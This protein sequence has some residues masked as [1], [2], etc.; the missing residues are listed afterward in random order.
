MS[1]SHRHPSTTIARTNTPP[2][3]LRVPAAPASFKRTIDLPPEPDDYD[4]NGPYPAG[5]FDADDEDIEMQRYL[6]QMYMS[7][8]KA[9]SFTPKRSS[10]KNETAEDFGFS[11]LGLIDTRPNDH[12]THN[13]KHKLKDDEARR[14][15]HRKQDHR[16]EVMA[17][18]SKQALAK[19]TA[20]R[21]FVEDRS[22]SQK[23]RREDASKLE[24][25]G[26]NDLPENE[27][28]E[29]DDLDIALVRPEEQ[30]KYGSTKS[31]RKEKG[32]GKVRDLGW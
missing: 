3:D 4:R 2:R 24:L 32:K 23:V 20:A 30:W 7:S 9:E 11:G 28:G 12:D 16:F 22:L 26:F 27:P 15:K 10:K 29:L 17:G 13:L 18:S 25:R 5:G 21:D 31:D 19:H 8:K 6:E 14:D 1:S